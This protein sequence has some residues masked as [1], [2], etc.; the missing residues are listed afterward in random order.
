VIYI[1]SDTHI[2][3]PGCNNVE[4]LAMLKGLNSDDRIIIS[5]DF[6]DLHYMQ[7]LDIFAEYEDLIIEFL[8]HLFVYVIGNHDYE[9]TKIK[10][11]SFFG[12]KAYY[13]EVITTID[14]K[15]W[16]ITHGHYFGWYGFIFRILERFYDVPAFRKI[17]KWVAKNEILSFMARNKV[18]IG[19]GVR[20]DALARAKELGC[21]VVICGHNHLPEIVESNGITYVNPGSCLGSIK[22]VTYD[23]GNF[24]LIGV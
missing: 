3:R 12:G 6:L 17:S 11:A 9:L 5:G 24:R 19:A 1:F 23:K 15:K 18:R 16:L 13:P 14:G 4:L 21:E 2:S 8:K 22:F 10:D 7:L 20:E